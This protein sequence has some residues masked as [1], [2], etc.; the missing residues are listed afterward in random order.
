MA[1]KNS[2]EAKFNIVDVKSGDLIN[3]M[4]E[5]DRVRR[6]KQD[7]KVKNAIKLNDKEDFIKVFVK[8]LLKLSTILTNSEAWFMT[9][10]LQYLDYTSGVLKNED[11]SCISIDDIMDDTNLKPSTAYGTLKNLCDKG[12]IMKC[13]TEGQVYIAMNPYIFMKGRMVSN[14]L[15]D[16]FKN[17]QWSE[18]FKED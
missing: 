1:K 16:L 11:G 15:V 14:T 9:Y 4:Y 2:K 12:I 18:I 6:K 13:K 3:V 7:D 5:G 10:L 17:T 8:P